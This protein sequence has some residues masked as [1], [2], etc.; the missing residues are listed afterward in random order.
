MN[1]QRY[2]VVTNNYV[3][4][5]RMHLGKKHLVVPV[6]M[7]VEG[8]HHGSN[9][10]LF[11][12]GDELSRFEA[13]W[14]GIPVVINHPEDGGRPISANVPDIIDSEV[15]GRVYN[16]HFSSGKLKAEAWLEED[17]LSRVSPEAFSYIREKKPL[18]VSVGVFTD[19]DAVSGTWNGED[20][21]A[22]SRNHRPDHLAL[23][24]G[25]RGACSWSDGCGVR[26]NAEGGDGVDDV[27][28]LKTLALSQVQVAEEGMRELIGAIQDK[29]DRM[30]TDSRVHF[31]EEA[32]ADDFVYRV[33]GPE[34]SPPEYL[35]R[36]YSAGE[37][38]VEF[39]DDVVPVVKKTEF[40]EINNNR[41]EQE[42][43]MEDERK[44]CCPEKVEL[45]V[46]SS[47]FEETDR[48]WLG[49]LDAD[50]LDKVIA[51]NVKAEE[52]PE[53]PEPVQMNEEQAVSVLKEQLSDPGR[54]MALLPSE[55]REQMEYGMKLYRDRRTGLIQGIVAN[56]EGVYS[57]DELGSMSIDALE[58]L[59]KLAKVAKPVAV[60]YSP[61]SGGSD[62][63]PT[64]NQEVLLP[65]GVTE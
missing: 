44:P 59:A 42:D 14:N 11:H 23:L 31:L 10:P 53:K 7:M 41:Q 47:A 5:T 58:K 26:A 48:D 24:P 65:A 27:K 37:G 30:D 57:E 6:I 25:A 43:K 19:D 35:K 60:N 52:E 32:Y 64:V 15:V 54:F 33:M 40:K 63:S 45:L 34:G 38:S 46:Q 12:P 29:L 61:L 9:G 1:I 51:L 17:S 18:D 22:V 50:Q 20:Y 8:V 16:T 49:E 36:N 28:T 13:A 3:P 2:S 39:G 21:T 4:L 55:T 56:S 62:L